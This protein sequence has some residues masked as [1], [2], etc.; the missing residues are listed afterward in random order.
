[1]GKYGEVRTIAT[2]PHNL[3]NGSLTF[4][5]SRGLIYG[6]YRHFSSLATGSRNRKEWLNLSHCTRRRG[7]IHMYIHVGTHNNLYWILV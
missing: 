5:P 2:Q 7:N 1:V 3:L 4:G 6:T